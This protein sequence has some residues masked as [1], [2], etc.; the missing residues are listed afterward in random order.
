MCS[1]IFV[2]IL[3]LSGC[4][5]TT[6]NQYSSPPH[7]VIAH[8]KQKTEEKNPDELQGQA[9]SIMPDDVKNHLLSLDI[10]NILSY[11]FRGVTV[12]KN[13]KFHPDIPLSRAEFVDVNDD[14]FALNAIISVTAGK[15][16]SPDNDSRF[17]PEVPITRAEALYGISVLQQTIE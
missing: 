4:A 3:L 5:R 7:P 14:Y 10:K 8:Q 15:I 11:N 17:R 12:D 16:M 6:V 9:I 1:S 2:C 13:N